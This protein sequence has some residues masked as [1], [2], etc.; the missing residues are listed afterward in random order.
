METKNVR[1]GRH[2][3]IDEFTLESAFRLMLKEM[4][5]G[6]TVY[7]AFSKRSF[8]ILV[9]VIA[10]S[11]IANIVLIDLLIRAPTIVEKMNTP[12]F[13][14]QFLLSTTAIVSGLWLFIRGVNIIT[15]K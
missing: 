14:I 11:I 7:L 10:M 2:K 5:S 9:F 13:V 8:H 12:I 4:K 15:D 1:N 6:N 3:K